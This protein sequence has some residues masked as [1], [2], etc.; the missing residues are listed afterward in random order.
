MKAEPP[1]ILQKM[2]K[3]HGGFM[4]LNFETHPTV[5]RCWL[6]QQ[7]NTTTKNEHESFILKFKIAG[8]AYLTIMS[9]MVFYWLHPSQSNHQ[10]P[11]FVGSHPQE[12]AIHPTLYDMKV[13]QGFKVQGCSYEV[14]RIVWLLYDIHVDMNMY[15]FHISLTY[16]TR[17]PQ[18][19]LPLQAFVVKAYQIS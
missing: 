8:V 2:L 9:P 16:P 15:T 18:P 12:A 3:I 10:A 1:E 4:V 17:R 14:H 13:V 5:G 6:V 11:A 19:L 7:S